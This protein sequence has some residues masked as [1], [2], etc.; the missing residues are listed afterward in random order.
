LRLAEQEADQLEGALLE[1]GGDD[2]DRLHAHAQA[3]LAHA[4][5]I[6]RQARL[7]EAPTPA[8]VVGEQVR[9]E[10]ERER[11]DRLLEVMDFSTWPENLGIKFS[12]YAGR[13]CLDVTV[14][15]VR[16]ID[17]TIQ[18]ARA[19]NVGFPAVLVPAAV[20]PPDERVVMF[21]TS[22]LEE[23]RLRVLPAEWS[24]AQMHGDW[25]SLRLK[26]EAEFAE[27][28]RISV[29]VV[30]PGA[31]TEAV[32]AA[33]AEPATS[34]TGN[35]FVRTAAG[36]ILTFE[37]V[38]AHLPALDGFGYIA[39]LCQNIGTD[40]PV[41]E[42]RRSVKAERPPRSSVPNDR[43]DG[44][45]TTTTERGVPVADD[46]GIAKTNAELARLREQ[47]EDAE[48]RNDVDRYAVLEA[49]IADLEK[50]LRKMATSRGAPRVSATNRDRLRNGVATVVDKAL[51][52]LEDLHGPAH[53]HF[54]KHLVV[55]TIC[56]YTPEPPTAWNVSDLPHS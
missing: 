44:L 32:P 45:T 7:S 8:T 13:H 52:R 17:D 35:S 20:A 11:I 6:G 16:G 39:Y 18:A 12:W 38:V 48:N 47:Q 41:E 53:A 1:R 2:L 37:G 51:G 23:L 55:R 33:A 42:L 22:A 4:A 14:Q 5:M 54:R 31:R 29:P 27:A 15:F 3:A 25:N 49:K 10:V 36:W 21:A 34:P 30:P 24:M 28:R 26:L 50:H 43:A 40:V 19:L 9:L 46:K 56:R